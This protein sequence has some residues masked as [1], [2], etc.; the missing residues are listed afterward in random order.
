M[1]L[2]KL[3]FGAGTALLLITG[4]AC[5]PKE[6]LQTEAPRMESELKTEKV[7]TTTL[8][9][10]GG[11]IVPNLTNTIIADFKEGIKVRDILEGSGIVKVSE[12]GESIVSV[13]D[14]ALD[15]TMEWGI[16]VNDKEVSA[17]PLNHMLNE[18]DRVEIFVKTTEV[19]PSS[20]LIK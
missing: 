8:E 15:P 16:K 6:A 14:V 3:I 12:D 17:E 4:S 9:I 13:N 1:K 5:S 7:P 2:T 20:N 11:K 18:N 10:N 19:D